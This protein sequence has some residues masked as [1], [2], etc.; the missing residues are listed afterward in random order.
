MHALLRAAAHRVVRYG[1]PL[2]LGFTVP[3]SLAAQAPLPGS[4]FGFAS[5]PTS[6]LIRPRIDFRAIQ[7]RFPRVRAAADERAMVVRGR[8][9]AQGLDPLHS[10]IYLRAFKHDRIL[11]L[12]ARSPGAGP[13]LKVAE[14]PI[15]A[16]SGQLGPK[17]K[18]GD[19][20]VPEG[21]Y[22]IDTFNPWSSYH[23]SLGLD[24]PNRADRLRSKPGASLGGDI[25]IHGDC[26][27]VGCLP[28]TDQLIEE[29]YWIAVQAR[30]AGQASIPV[31]VFPTRMDEAGMA[32]LER[33]A[34]GNPGLM[35]FWRE[36]E[37]GYREF[38][39]NR[40]VPNVFVDDDGRYIVKPALGFPLGILDDGRF[41]R[42]AL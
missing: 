39:A 26:K 6:G 1:L 11:E 35:R 34:A 31:H 24:Y 15:C 10:E 29:I 23:L 5:L 21:F 9:A 16:I 33:M 25:F 7:L 20:Q 22:S 4:G 30:G 40:A 41:F 28:M 36:L 32:Y 8:F 38:E 17:R 18:K 14:Y 2:A 27:T 42:T 13:F 37:P 12:W 3:S 19:E